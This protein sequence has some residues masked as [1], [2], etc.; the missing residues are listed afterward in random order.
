MKKHLLLLP[1]ALFVIASLNAQTE[2]HLK[3]LK[4][5]TYGGDN[6]EAYFSYDDKNLSF[7]SN[8]KAWGLHCDQIYNMNIADAAK[9]TAYR[10]PRISTGKGRTT[11]AYYLK[12]GK[13]ILYASTHLAGDAC[14]PDPAPRPDHK[15]I[16][17]VYPSFDIFIADL[18]TS[19]F[20]FVIVDSMFSL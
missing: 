14:P 4:Q 15:Y 5:L 9:D 16:W 6:A 7:Q 10:P 20:V 12:D 17:A 18:T 11:C 1:T 19:I 3:N 2:K 13:H 8:N